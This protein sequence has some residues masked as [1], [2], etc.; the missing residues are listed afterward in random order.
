LKGEEDVQVGFRASRVRLPPMIGQ[1]VRHNTTFSFGPTDTN[2]GN[3]R[4]SILQDRRDSP[5]R[6]EF[7]IC[8]LVGSSHQVFPRA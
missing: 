5:H 4:T 7:V 3:L 1:Q 8:L 6:H 2:W